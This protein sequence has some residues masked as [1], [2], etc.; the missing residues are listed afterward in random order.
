MILW[1]CKIN[2][3]LCSKPHL[4]QEKLKSFQWP[5]ALLTYNLYYLSFQLLLF[6]SLLTPFQPQWPLLL[7]L[8]HTRHAASNHFLSGVVFL[9][10]RFYLIPSPSSCLSS[11]SSL[12]FSQWCL[13]YLFTS[14][15]RTSSERKGGRER[16]RERSID[17]RNTDWLPSL[18]APTRDQ[19]CNP[20]MYVPCESN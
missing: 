9:P 10:I 17:V 14:H 12:I 13:P 6:P 3:F 11:C 16:E 15:W 5:K 18:R 8:K 1:T 19:T 2:S 4:N 7:F 20:C